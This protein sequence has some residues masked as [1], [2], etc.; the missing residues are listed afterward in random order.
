MAKRNNGVADAFDMFSKTFGMTRQ[1]MHAKGTRDIMDAKPEEAYGFNQ[2]EVGQVQAAVDSGQYDVGY[3]E[4]RKGYT[5]APKADPSQVGF[6]GQAPMTR[7][8]GRDHQG[9]MTPEQLDTA[10][11]SAMADVES[12]YDPARGLQ[13][14]RELR[15][16]QREDKRFAREERMAPIQEEAAQLGLETARR[17]G[18]H[19]ERDDAVDDLVVA[20]HKEYTGDAAQIGQ[21]AKYLNQN[22]Q[23]ISMGGRD[24]KGFVRLSV[25][26]PD[27]EAEFLKLTRQDQSTLFAAGKIMEVHPMKALEMMAGVNKN[28]ALA[29]AQENGMADKLAGNANDT[30]YKGGML[31]VA[32]QNASTNEAY[33][34]QMGA[35]A[36]ARAGGAGGAGKPVKMDVETLDPVTGRKAKVQVLVNPATGEAVT[37]DGRP[38]KDS[39]AL[40]RAMG[41]MDQDARIS[42]AEANDLQLVEAAFKGGQLMPQPGQ[43]PMQALE[44]AR[45]EVRQGYAMQ[46]GR[47]AFA[48]LDAQERVETVRAMAQ[49]S[50]KKPEE[51][52]ALVG[53][54]PEFVRQ[55]LKGA[56]KAS[57]LAPRMVDA[58]T[59]PVRQI[60]TLTPPRSAAEMRNQA[61]PVAPPTDDELLIQSMGLT[62]RTR[63]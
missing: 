25:V 18:R 40:D 9:Q 36:G 63:P 27:G 15:S 21:T 1:V 24:E 3:D 50:G 33:R 23:R 54:D 58:P 44:A 41:R 26:K 55:A 61:R 13:M 34:R 38:F 35:A 20:A 37:A 19:G 52:A 51:I 7:F 59:R 22:S 57:G 14:R 49:A 10:R 2:D 45:N 11:Y 4:A 60:T 30:A 39:V 47:S 6:V 48:G 16:Q 62:P 12:K 8:L 29:I 28:L 43:N 42:A 32:Q 56:P 46:R 31:G 5:V 17:T 53:A